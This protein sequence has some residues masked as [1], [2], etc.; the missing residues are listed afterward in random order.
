MHKLLWLQ[1][2]K[3]VRACKSSVAR[4]YLIPHP[5]IPIALIVEWYPRPQPRP[6]PCPTTR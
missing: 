6:W 2:E 4:A 5:P 1:V 3:T